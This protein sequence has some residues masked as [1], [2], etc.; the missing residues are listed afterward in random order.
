MCGIGIW[1]QAA[2]LPVRPAVTPVVPTVAPVVPV[3]PGQAEIEVAPGPSPTG[4]PAI[5][6][7]VP[8]HAALPGV[9]CCLAAGKL[10]HGLADRGEPLRHALLLRA[11]IL[12]GDFLMSRG[13]CGWAE[14][15]RHA[16]RA[17]TH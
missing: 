2:R 11:R 1:R 8:G 5:A 7:I 12:Q 6:P 9:R 13:R 14:Q 15:Y 4:T 3:A 16:D 10:R 17:G